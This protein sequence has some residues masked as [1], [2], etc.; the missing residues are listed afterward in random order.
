MVLFQDRIDVDAAKLERLLQLVREQYQPGAERRGMTL[1][2]SRISPPI[3][4]ERSHSTLWLRWQVESI[5]AWWAMRAQAGTAG[6]A[7]FW[8][9]IDSFCAF[10]ERI[11][12][13]G[14]TQLP[15]AEAVDSYQVNTR[16]HRETAQLCLRDKLTD[17]DRGQFLTVLAQAEGLPGIE[18]LSLGENLAP[19]YAAGHYT[20]DLLFGDEKAAFAA[21]E[22]ELWTGTLASALDRYCETCHALTLETLGAGLRRST[23]K[24]AIKRTAY[25]RLLP[26]IG[27]DVAKRFEQDL[28]EMPAQIPEILNWRLSRAIELPWNR[29]GQAAW[30]YVWEQEFET[31]DD[32]LGPYMVNP[33]HWAHIDRWFD[34][35][36]GVQAIDVNL[37]H[38]F[39]PLNES[40]MAQEALG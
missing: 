9:Q 11:Y 1:L 31:V 38:A 13:T 7:E 32:L 8:S 23:L 24:G 36:S 4:L 28:L 27:N 30:T 34:P 26:D 33:H 17:S 14:S 37:S 20:W 40:L 25:F 19:E 15:Q 12:L 35:E 2:E 10:R 16:G 22:S 29:A 6:V 39:S 18:A 3:K 21:R 5:P